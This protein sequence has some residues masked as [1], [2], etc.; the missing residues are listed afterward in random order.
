MGRP[1][2]GS[3]GVATEGAQ[4][5]SSS[6][7]QRP[8]AEGLRGAPARPGAGATV[9]SCEAKASLEGRGRAQGAACRDSPPPHGDVS[10][11]CLRRGSWG[12]WS[13]GRGSTEEGRWGRGGPAAQLRSERLVRAP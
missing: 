1:P 7:P 13:A 9:G 11:C 12:G 6:G 8:I 2:R 5:G 10:S 4:T 3:T